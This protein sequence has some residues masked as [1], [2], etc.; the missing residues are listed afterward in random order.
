[1]SA[2]AIRPEATASGQSRQVTQSNLTDAASCGPPSY[3]CSDQST[4]VKPLCRD[5]SLPVV[6]D[7]SAKPN[8]VYYDKVFASK[9]AGNQIVRCTYPE[10]NPQGNGS[11]IIGFG[12]SGDSNAI[13]KAGGTPPSYRLII[14]GAPFTYIP[15]PGH[16]VCRPTYG[17]ISS[18]RVADGSFSWIKPHL[19]YAFAGNHFKVLAMDLGS[20]SP[21]NRTPIV[22]FQQA[23]P[24][25]GVDWPG[26]NRAIPLGTILKPSHNNN[27]GYLYQA[28]CPPAQTACASG[29]TGDRLPSFNPTIMTDTADGT[30][31]WRNIGVGFDNP[32]T[33][34]TI[35]GVSTDD[36]VFVKGVGDAGGQGGSGAL[37]VVAYKRSA[38]L[39]FLY[40]VGTGIVSYF[41]CNAGTSYS[42]SGGSWAE[43]ILGMTTL[44]DRFVL[45]NV[46]VNKSG[47]WV[48]ITQ[49]DC[50]Y[51][52]CSIVPG[53]FGPYLWQLSTTGANVHKITSHP[54]GHWTEGFRL[55]ANQNGDPGVWI[56]GRSFAN[57]DDQFPLND[58]AASGPAPA[59]AVDA[60]PSWNYNDGTDTTPICTNTVAFDWPYKA[61]GEN[62]VVCFGTNPDPNCSSPGHGLCRDVTK[63]FFHTYNPATCNQYDGFWSC[64]GIGALSQDG[65]YYAF[66]SN[67]GDTLGSTSKGGYGTGSCVG[68]FNFQKNHEYRVGDVFEPGNGTGN[69]HPNAGFTVFKVTV[70]GSSGG[71][72]KGA[73]PRS[74]SPRRDAADGYYRNGATILPPTSHNPCNHAFR[75]EG[76]GV[77]SGSSPPDWKKAY[78]YDG[79][80]QSAKSGGTIKDGGITWS[81]IGEYVLGTMHL[82]NL[83]RDDCRSDVFIGELK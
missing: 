56:N 79:S 49:D 14:S 83:G 58:S 62:E 69:G 16:P 51:R 39:Y 35:G 7:M 37:F 8:A 57:P 65:K 6:P 52:T 54:Y 61:P 24:R 72:P 19:Y 5:C 25:R 2:L 40:N 50:R 53:S 17:S 80:C 46:K 18:F 1:V 82:A 78:D 67:W 74:W 43:T 63:R 10:M 60:H 38:N 73:W 28:T 45:H 27:G 68:G 81:D 4:D 66:T 59:D 77:A 32:S 36:D 76:G 22:D 41:K 44:P 30:V 33:W 15:D 31:T 71:Y 70:A 34:S 9:D 20:P 26:A 55:F 48:V 64:W 3:P 11:F 42:C 21:P 75:V 12:G 13:G 29:T 23:L 47:E